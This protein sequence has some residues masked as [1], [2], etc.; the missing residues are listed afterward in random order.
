MAFVPQ[1]V[2]CSC[3]LFSNSFF[4]FF[5]TIFVFL[6]MKFTLPKRLPDVARAISSVIIVQSSILSLLMWAKSFWN[7]MDHASQLSPILHIS[8]IT[9]SC[10]IHLHIMLD[11]PII[12]GVWLHQLLPVG[13]CRNLMVFGW[14]LVVQ[15]FAWPTNLW[16][17]CLGF[18]SVCHLFTLYKK[19]GDR[20][21][22]TPLNFRPSKKRNEC[23]S[24][25][26]RLLFYAK[27]YLLCF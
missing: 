24:L 5:F 8:H 3:F 1:F 26:Q 2:G 10:S 16:A 11:Q 23:F 6:L 4:S 27:F 19:L 15:I 20:S 13:I 7:S 21:I 12:I 14:L 22:K 9:N 18:L 25:R 17:S